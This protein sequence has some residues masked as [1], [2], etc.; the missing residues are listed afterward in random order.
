MWATAIL[1]TRCYDVTWVSAPEGQHV[2]EIITRVI[3]SKRN[4]NKNPTAIQEKRK[5]ERKKREKER[6]RKEKNRRE[7]K[8]K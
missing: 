3:R 2:N 6:E 7:N 5:V 1:T 8:I 4:Y